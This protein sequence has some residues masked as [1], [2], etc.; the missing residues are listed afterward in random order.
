LVELFNKRAARLAFLG[1]AFMAAPHPIVMCVGSFVAGA[2]WLSLGTK[3]KCLVGLLF[4]VFGSLLV[5]SMSGL[6]S[7]PSSEALQSHVTSDL[8]LL[9]VLMLMLGALLYG[10]LSIALLDLGKRL[11][12]A[13]FRIS[14]VFL[15]I[16]AL[17]M[18]SLGLLAF[19]ALAW[20]YVPNPLGLHEVLAFFEY[21]TF[22]LVVSNSLGNILASAGFVRRARLISVVSEKDVQVTPVSVKVKW[23]GHAAFQ[24][25]FKGKRLLIDPW[26]S[27]P[28]SPLKLENLEKVDYVIVTHDHLDHLGEAEQIA[29]KFNSTVIGVPELV[30]PLESKGLNVLGMNMGSLV[31]VEGSFKIALVPALHTCG[32]GQ[33]VGVVLEV[34]S[35]RLYHMGD[36]GYTSEFQAVKEVF[37]P[38]V[39]FVPIGGH[40]TMGPKEAALAVK[41]LRPK[42]AIPMHYATL[43]VLV[44]T[45]DGFVDAVKS[46]APEVKVLVL[47]PGEEIEL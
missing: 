23:L 44:K 47:K 26:I 36:T 25:T 28:L 6:L 5:V 38:D 19:L 12:E 40:Y 39:V 30:V 34:D 4:M 45:A 18:F 17:T 35:L 11:K 2:G 7:L 32:A 15:A 29:K 46:L 33:P 41:V 9:A 10:L 31:D 14:V 22:L 37:N 43:P 16:A 20:S 24:L 1:H 21:S 8:M 42:I 3:L 27:N 13:L